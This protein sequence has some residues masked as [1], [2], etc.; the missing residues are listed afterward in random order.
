MSS[1]HGPEVHALWE[2]FDHQRHIVATLVTR[3]DGIQWRTLCGRDFQ[4]RT[5]TTGPCGYCPACSAAKAAVEQ[6]K[7]QPPPSP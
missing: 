6:R 2:R 1:R 3:A 5:T 4:R 7:A